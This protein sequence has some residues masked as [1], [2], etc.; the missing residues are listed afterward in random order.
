MVAKNAT[1]EEM[2]G[3]PEE[4]MDY[5]FKVARGRG[6]TRQDDLKSTRFD[7]LAAYVTGLSAEETSP[8]ALSDLTLYLRDR[9]HREA[10]ADV[11]GKIAHAS[12]VTQSHRNHL[13]GFSEPQHSA[14]SGMVDI[15]FGKGDRRTQRTYH[16]R[17]THLSAMA[18]SL[19]SLTANEIDDIR[20][21]RQRFAQ[22]PY[23]DRKNDQIL[24]GRRT[25]LVDS[26]GSVIEREWARTTTS[27]PASGNTIEIEPVAF[28]P[29]APYVDTGAV[30]NTDFATDIHVTDAT[31]VAPVLTYTHPVHAPSPAPRAGPVRRRGL[32][33]RAL[34]F[35]AVALAGL[36]A[37]ATVPSPSRGAITDYASPPAIEYASPSAPA[38]GQT[39]L[40]A[41]AAAAYVAPL[42]VTPI[43]APSVQATPIA[44]AARAPEPAKNYLIIG[45]D[46]HT[47][48]PQGR[49]DALMVVNIVPDAGK[50]NVITIP[51]D[52]KVRVPG[53]GT[54][55]IN[56]AFAYGGPALQIAT[57]ED[58]T[59]L[60]IDG[61]AAADFDTFRTLY[62]NLSG[63]FSLSDVQVGQAQVAQGSPAAA[64]AAAQPQP[65]ADQ[66]LGDLRNRQFSNAAVGRANNLGMFTSNMALRVLD[67]SQGMSS[68]LLR[69]I[70]G[71]GTS[72]IDTDI[73]SSEIVRMVDL[74]N[75]GKVDVA[76]YTVPGKPN[77]WPHN[78]ERVSYWLPQQL[79]GS[80]GQPYATRL[81]DFCNN[82]GNCTLS[83]QT[84]MPQGQQAPAPTTV[85]Q[86]QSFTHPLT[87]GGTNV[88]L[89]MQERQGSDTV[90]INLHD[91][92][93]TS[94][95]AAS[96][97]VQEHGGR[98]VQLEY[99]S[100]A[101]RIKFGLKGKPY[102]FDPNGMFTD[103]G[104]ERSLRMYGP[105]N[106][107]AEAH[108]AVRSFAKQVV[109][110]AGID[111]APLVVALHNNTPGAFSAS[112]Y[113]HDDAR[114]MAD[115]AAV[116]T[117]GSDPDDFFF[118]TNEKLFDSLKGSGFSVVLQDNRKG[119]D[120]G[121]LSVYAGQRGIAY[122][123]SEAQH[124]HLAQQR[125]ML[126]ILANVPLGGASYTIAAL[127]PGGSAP[128]K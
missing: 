94:V 111:H 58:F 66:V 29:P 6:R 127:S 108:A 123:N 20:F 27:N 18:D 124:G 73:P 21:V 128:G 31:G 56:H 40:S 77:G 107:S 96:A 75:D 78:G 115:A 28:A 12:S 51:R 64:Q 46:A 103:A 110:F 68:L 122:A 17:I 89:K 79:Q 112:S 71:I 97:F 10:D 92:E 76:T 34:Q 83:A 116:H 37:Y 38:L 113:T 23:L 19:Q 104:I 69:T 125:R 60:H 117:A 7:N 61:Y 52:S 95:D 42:D 24:Q 30:A 88:T 99:G 70:A 54:T 43:P 47:K 32:F 126:D 85:A 36:A 33:K 100:N 48:D 118:V 74:L 26:L 8:D 98:L 65:S 11:A 87:I 16:D 25:G 120:D 101:R 106:Y 93:N 63:Y 109:D 53:H 9:A 59:G 102:E 67:K 90:Y 49:A 22:N 86:M 35:G 1:L 80:Q 72:I 3:A 44:R 84:Y 55:K 39:P 114:R 41:P 119:L 121:S 45:E 82:G 15:A 57:V 4:R 62:S 14:T 13:Y 50:I 5:L 2:A 105:K 81:M 91:N